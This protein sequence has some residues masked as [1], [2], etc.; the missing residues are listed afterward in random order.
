M[1]LNYFQILMIALNVATTKSLSIRIGNSTLTASNNGQ[2]IHFTFGQ[3][4]VTIEEYLIGKT[5]SFQVGS[6]LVTVTTP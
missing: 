3:A 1:K 4:M 6:I 5:G 2:P